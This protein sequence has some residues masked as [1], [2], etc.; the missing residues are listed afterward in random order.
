MTDGRTY[1]VVEDPE[2]TTCRMAD[3][4][5]RPCKTIEPPAVASLAPKTTPAAKRKP[6]PSEN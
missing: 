3:G 6:R 1:L 2:W 5:E 4:R